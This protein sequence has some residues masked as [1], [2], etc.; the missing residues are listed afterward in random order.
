MNISI[1]KSI[2][3]NPIFVPKNV[4]VFVWIHEFGMLDDDENS[5]S[6]AQSKFRRIQITLSRV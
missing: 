2:A 1:F 6:R 3:N 4:I 5:V